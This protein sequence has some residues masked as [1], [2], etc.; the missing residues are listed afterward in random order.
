MYLV[1][2]RSRDLARLHKQGQFWHILFSTGSVIISQDEVETWTTHVPIALD[3]DQASLNPEKAVS[4][5]LGGSVGPYP[6]KIDEIL[7]TSSWRPNICIA[8]R[9]ISP[10]GRVFL[11]GDSAHQNAPFG[12]YG[13]NTALGD[14]FDI[15]WKLAAVL[16]GYGGPHL[17]KSYETERRPIAVRNIDHSG[18]H[19][20]VHFEWWGWCREAGSKVVTSQTED[21]KKLRAQITHQL[22]EHDGENKD[23]GIELDYR[24]NH[25]PVIVPDE[26]STE[27][28]W[29]RAQYTPS[30]WPG[31][32]APHVFLADGETS[33]FD[34]FGR[35]YT[36]IDFSKDGKVAKTFEAMAKSLAIP[37]KVVCLPNEAHAQDVWGRSAFLIRPDDHVAWRAPSDPQ[38]EVD[39][40]DILLIVVGR[41]CSPKQN[42]SRLG[43]SENPPL[44]EG[45]FASTIGNV[46]QE[47]VEMLAEFQ[48]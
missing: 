26:K 25:S 8:D 31:A 34:L 7:V 37:L 9:Y 6:I 30:T 15:G 19:A 21:G 18:V 44:A 28:V 33:I 32:R 38:A 1:H 17:L 5:V 13:M 40:E 41:R 14:S 12:G 48:K 47:K 46:D 4:E 39:V 29:N 35:Y 23:H 24:Y 36:F 42:S 3:V 27:P 11:S 16:G 10:G 43:A 45:N 22:Q 2:F 20:A